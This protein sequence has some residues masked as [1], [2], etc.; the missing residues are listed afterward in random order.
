[1]KLFHSYG[2]CR[3][4]TLFSW[5]R[6]NIELWYAPRNYEIVEHKHSNEDIELMFLFGKST[7]FRRKFKTMPEESVNV[8]FPRSLFKCMTV[9]AGYFHRFTVNRFSPL[10]FINIERWKPGVRITSA[11]MDFQLE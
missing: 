10:V 7:F 5:G 9:P 11:S 2:P 4:I 1:M 3:G 6:L 8:S